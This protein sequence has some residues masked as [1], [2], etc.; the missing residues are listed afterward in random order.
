MAGQMIWCALLLSRRL[1]LQTPRLAEINMYLPTDETLTGSDL[2][3][4]HHYSC[5]ANEWGVYSNFPANM[6]S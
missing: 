2:L 3:C 6:I 5:T 1:K 4:R